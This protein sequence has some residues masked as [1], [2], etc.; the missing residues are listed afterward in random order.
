MH[1]CPRADPPVAPEDVFVRQQMSGASAQQLDTKKAVTA[2]R[3]EMLLI[4]HSWS[5]SG[6]E[7]RLLA[8]YPPKAG[9]R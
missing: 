1:R 8:Q 7:E 6:A 2:E 3:E 4:Q 9:A 5:L